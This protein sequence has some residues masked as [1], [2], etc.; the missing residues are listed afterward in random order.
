MASITKIALKDGTP[1][2]RVRYRDENHRDRERRFPRLSDATA[3]AAGVEHGRA[4]GPYIDRATG[5]RPFVSYGADVL[6]NRRARPST[7]AGNDS[8]WRR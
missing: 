7:R 4:A 5:N 2:W 6:A 8:R 3:F 1:A